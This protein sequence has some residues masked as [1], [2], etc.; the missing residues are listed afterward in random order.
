MTFTI[1]NTINVSV[2]NIMRLIMSD[3]AMEKFSWSGTVSAAVLAKTSN[4]ATKPPFN[5]L[6]G[7][8]ALIELL[9][10]RV[11]LTQ[12]EVRRGI[13]DFIRRAPERVRRRMEGGKRCDF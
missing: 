12:I 8:I 13:K 11:P 5:K 9:G 7:V 4:V 1:G 2:G 3:D 10:R 6:N